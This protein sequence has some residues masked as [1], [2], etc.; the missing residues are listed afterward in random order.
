MNSP[1][2]ASFDASHILYRISFSAVFLFSGAT[3]LIN[4]NGA[5]TEMATFGLPFPA[6]VAAGVIGLQLSGGLSILIGRFVV[7]AALALAAFTAAATLLA[8]N[9]FLAGEG[10]ALRQW[11]VLLEHL[12]M[13]G[14]LVLFAFAHRAA[15]HERFGIHRRLT[16]PV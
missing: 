1:R 12:T 3:K 8:H 15:S 13:V 11:T 5:M 14:G 6:V 2:R 7:P 10:E 16:D 9:P 4:Y